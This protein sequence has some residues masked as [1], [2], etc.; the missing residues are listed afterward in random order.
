M[1]YLPPLKI[2]IDP[3]GLRG[4]KLKLSK[5][6]ISTNLFKAVLRR[7]ILKQLKPN[8]PR[9]FSNRLKLFFLNLI[10]IFKDVSKK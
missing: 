9:D 2:N 5:G 10:P 7:Q 6:E 4:L 8:Q 3:R 1:E